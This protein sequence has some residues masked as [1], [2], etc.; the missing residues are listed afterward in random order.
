MDNQVNHL[1]SLLDDYQITRDRDLPEHVWE[2]IKKEKFFGMIIPKEYGGLGFSAHGHSM[3]YLYIL[4]HISMLYYAQV[5]NNY[6][7]YRLSLKSL[8]KVARQLSL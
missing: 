7:A 3:V 4:L 1:C 2:Y 6:L 5:L 8:V